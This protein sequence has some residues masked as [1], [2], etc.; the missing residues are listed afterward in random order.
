[1]DVLQPQSSSQVPPPPRAQGC[2]CCAAGCGT[3][4]IIA[5]AGLTLV[6]GGLWYG[7]IRMVDAMTASHPITVQLEEPS[8][9][10]FAAANAKVEQLRNAAEAQEQ[11]TVEFTATDLNAL[12]ARHPQFTRVRGKM[13]VA[14]ADSIA[15]LDLSIPLTGIPLPRVRHRWFNG[16]T[17]FG[18]SYDEEGFRFSPRG[19]EANGYTIAEELFSDLAPTINSYFDREYAP[20]QDRATQRRRDDEWERFWQQ[21]R[22]LTVSDGKVLVTTRGPATSSD[23]PAEALEDDRAAEESPPGR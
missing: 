4:L 22:S 14:V 20:P 3:L 9:E 5:I 17:S 19:L 16:S 18:L 12:V 7:Y 13:R 21:L 6:L 11:V 23:A 8:A 10:Q 2:G 15:K 1:M